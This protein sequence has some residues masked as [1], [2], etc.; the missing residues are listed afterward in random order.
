LRLLEKIVSLRGLL[1]SELNRFGVKNFWVAD[2]IAA[3]L[4]IEPKVNRANNRELL[5]DIASK[6][7]GDNIYFTGAGY[8]NIATVIAKCFH[9]LSSGVLKSSDQMIAASVSGPV[10]NPETYYWRGIVS[11]IGIPSLVLGHHGGGG[12]HRGLKLQSRTH[13]Y[14]R[15]GKN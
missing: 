5:P 8:A 14:A 12:S 1:K 7:A 4:G 15:R 11:P 13:P 6:I 10:K 3:L 2:G 9:G